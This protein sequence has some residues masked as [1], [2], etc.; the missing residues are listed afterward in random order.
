MS[1]SSETGR[2]PASNMISTGDAAFM[3]GVCKKTLYRWEQSG[4]FLP[5]F[6]TA[7][8][9]RRYDRRVILILLRQRDGDDE[10]NDVGEVSRNGAVANAAIHARVSSTRQ[11]QSGDLDRQASTVSSYCEK[12]GFRVS[13]VY[14]DVGS[15]L[16][17]G[18]RGL[19]N[20]LKDVSR[21]YHDVVV[22]NYQDRLSRFGVNVIRAFLSSWGVDLV[23]VNK[24]IEADDPNT[25]LV[26]ALMS[27]L[28]SFMGRIYRQRRGKQVKT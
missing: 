18:R 5:A 22:V 8:N 3:M 14:S 27:I 13:R 6:R 1:I 2:C 17:D 28:Y 15:G 16:N 9:H 7:G 21:G 19:L 24:S 23:V 20:L 11:K 26:E 12:R 4:K 25:E 10:P